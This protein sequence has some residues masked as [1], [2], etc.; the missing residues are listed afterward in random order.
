MKGELATFGATG[1]AAV[2]S[3]ISDATTHPTVIGGHP[4]DLATTL[5]ALAAVLS[6][7]R[8]LLREIRDFREKGRAK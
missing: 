8:L 1:G 3:V 6:G 5:L 7:A 4:I 2:L